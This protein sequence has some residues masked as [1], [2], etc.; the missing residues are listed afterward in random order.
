MG[1]RN[2]IKVSFNATTHLCKKNLHIVCNTFIIIICEKSFCTLFQTKYCAFSN[3]FF[4]TFT[5]AHVSAKRM[6][7]FSNTLK[8]FTFPL[9]MFSLC[10]MSPN[11]Q[12]LLL[13]LVSTNYWVA[14]YLKS[15][16]IYTSFVF[17][18]SF[19]N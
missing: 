10:W 16:I 7:I 2:R 1:S 13:G 5:G 9:K 11:P 4:F 15:T 19:S 3:F 18:H 17:F 8:M 14:V 12:I 6:Q